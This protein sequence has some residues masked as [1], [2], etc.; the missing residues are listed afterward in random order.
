MSQ[1]QQVKASA[2]SGKT[3]EITQRF[4][5]FLAQ[6]KVQAHVSHCGLGSASAAPGTNSAPQQFSWGDIMAITFTNMATLEMKHRVIKSL[7]EVA[8][9]LAKP[10][11]NFNMHESTAKAWINTIL[12]QY[13]ALNIR[14]I[15]SLLHLIVRTAALDMGFSPDFES[16]FDINEIM[17]PIFEALLEEAE[18]GNEDILAFME[19]I[20]HYLLHYEKVKGFS[21]G[22]RI[23]ET[24]L[25]IVQL[26]L[27]H[28]LPH[29][30]PTTEI[31]AKYDLIQSNWINSGIKMEEIIEAENLCASSNA[32][33]FFAK[34]ANGEKTVFTSA[35]LQKTHLD[36][37]L[38]KA[39]KGMASAEAQ[40]AFNTLIQSAL[41]AKDT[42]PP[43]YNALKI[44]PF[45]DLAILI[46]EQILALQEQDG[47]VPN[48]S[49]PKFV[50][51]I[52]H[53]NYGVSAAL[54]RIGNSVHHVLLDEFQ[55]TSREQWDALSPLMQEALARGGSLTWVGDV[56][57]AIYGWRGGDADL[58]DELLTD[59][60][61]I[62]MAKPK[63][64]NLKINWRSKENI[65]HTNNMLF[66][67]FQDEEIARTLLACVVSNSCPAHL[68]DEGTQKLV[69]AYNGVEQKV[70]ANAEGGYVCIERLGDTEAV[71]E[72]LFEEIRSK[73]KDKLLQDIAP[74]RAWSD[75]AILVRKKEHATSVAG[76]LLDWGIPVITENSL[77]LNAHPLIQ[78]SLALLAFLHSPEDNLSFWT[79]LTGHI[80]AC[81]FR[82]EGEAGH[83]DATKPSLQELHAWRVS[84]S[85]QEYELPLYKLFMEKWPSFW[86]QSFAPFYSQANILT[87]Y[88]CIQE[89]YRLW[90]VEERFTEAQTFVRRFLEIV[91]SAGEKGSATLGTFLELWKKSG[92]QEKTPM[93]NN[94]N[95]VQIL[96]IHKSKGLQFP[97][98][99][100]PW[101]NFN[102]RDNDDIILHEIDGLSM[103]AKMAPYSGDVYYASQVKGALESINLL[104][105]ACT[106]AE[107]ELYLFHNITGYESKHNYLSNA[108]EVLF[109][110][111]DISLPYEYGTMSLSD[112][113]AQ[114]S[115]IS[116][117]I[118]ARP[119]APVHI[120]E[121]P[122][123]MDWL[124]RLKIYREPLQNLVLDTAE[125]MHSA[126]LSPKQRGLLTHH[127]LETLHN[128][129]FDA[130]LATQEESLQ[131]LVHMSIQSFALPI[132]AS[133]EL[134]QELTDTLRWY[135]SLPG[136]EQWLEYGVPEQSVLCP[137]QWIQGKENPLYRIDLL[138]PPQKAGQGYRLIDF[139]TGHAD[140]KYLEQ[141]RN[142]M[143]LLDAMP[144]N[145]AQ[146]QSMPPSE[147]MLLYLDLKK[148]CMVTAS[149]H[150]EL[151]DA[152]CW[153]GGE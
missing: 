82:E 41:A 3:Y 31:K 4:L 141:V 47:K 137:P 45:L 139:K 115:N 48:S 11:E 12:R 93:P 55:D 118:E 135:M 35:Y 74:R 2:G 21:M 78:E 33:K 84:H 63:E 62:S 101:T 114:N 15:D 1:M 80:M 6:S 97:V 132:T 76:W 150:S 71:K 38:N 44:H 85:A 56:K 116:E 87:P 72:D 113:L 65:V 88:D 24:I 34:C 103:L 64:K 25:P 17:T 151:L 140:E 53:F 106:R 75:V 143:Q 83:S 111:L 5:H 142:Y 7:K 100:V 130:H 134:I 16:S 112:C 18:Q 147:G 110:H 19:E 92:E 46:Y 146:G 27:S 124:P 58:F 95:A 153:Q 43:L 145:T 123:L 152:P 90:Q 32:M 10:S 8:L 148:C 29:L 128:V 119:C 138:L 129:G 117:E 102:N 9:G 81:A 42:S 126:Q 13:S 122:E 125:D 77:L 69:K 68:L 37:C 91:F 66:K 109:A 144:A 36:E 57:Q 30:S 52:L 105:V 136:I 59:T 149:S 79:V 67:P 127:C 26:L 54:C 49:M 108:L 94:V 131:N 20:C 86:E 23:E 61:L 73:L 40:Q 50:Q 96:T 14:T 60:D 98:V 133:P 120:T 89:W 70:K 22:E 121:Q 99:I 39:S 104:Y 28:E 107:E 51:D